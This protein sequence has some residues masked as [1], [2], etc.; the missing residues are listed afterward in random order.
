MPGYAIRIRT[1]RFGGHDFR[2]RSLSGLQQHA[3]P[4]PPARRLGISSAQWR[5]FGHVWPAGRSLAQAM[6]D[7]DV[8]GKHALELG[9]GLGLASADGEVSITSPGRGNSAPF[10]RAMRKR[11]YEAMERRAPMDDEDRPPYRGRL[12]S[13]RR[14]V[15]GG[16]A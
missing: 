10:T 13:Y 9:C 11:E 5:L 15:G 16:T 1:L 12:L 7:H 2:I 3:D 14:A 6:A 8:A 4:D